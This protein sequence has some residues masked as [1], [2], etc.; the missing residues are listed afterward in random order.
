M[1][2]GTCTQDEPQHFVFEKREKEVNSVIAPSELLVAPLHT[3]ITRMTRP[4]CS[5]TL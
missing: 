3:M 2:I 1:N 5:Y 4:N